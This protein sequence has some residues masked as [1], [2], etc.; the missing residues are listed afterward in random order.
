MADRSEHVLECKGRDMWAFTTLYNA[1][2]YG[3]PSVP[4]RKL[5]HHAQFS[6]ILRPN[7]YCVF[8][9]YDVVFYD[10][11]YVLFSVIL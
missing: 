7:P 5:Q 2:T 6:A 4:K 11:D 3:K 1:Y 10:L 9:F 8:A